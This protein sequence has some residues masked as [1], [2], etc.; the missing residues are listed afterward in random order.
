[1][2]HLK[3]FVSTKL[4]QKTFGRLTAWRSST[5]ANVYSEDRNREEDIGKDRENGR[6]INCGE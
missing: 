2:N 5:R 1:M 4:P 3:G 6:R